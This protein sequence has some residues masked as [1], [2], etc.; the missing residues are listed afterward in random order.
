MGLHG[1][2]LAH[3]TLMVASVGGLEGEV[4]QLLVGLAVVIVV[5]HQGCNSHV[6]HSRSATDIIGQ[7]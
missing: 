3:N 5:S 7:L 1:S 2:C 6:N 4:M